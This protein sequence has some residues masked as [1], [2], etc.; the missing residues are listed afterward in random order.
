MLKYEFAL[1]I[2]DKYLPF[3]SIN[4]S[5]YKELIAYLNDFLL[6]FN[7]ALMSA[8]CELSFKHRKF[9]AI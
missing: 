5:L 3:I 6:I 2:P 8:G 7:S 1:W 9:D 4:R